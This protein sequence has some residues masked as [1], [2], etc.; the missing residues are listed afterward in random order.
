MAQ[1]A[2][3][4]AFVYGE[5][6]NGD[7]LRGLGAISGRLLDVGSGA[8]AW[9]VRLRDAGAQELVA[10][11]PS[12]AAVAIAR[13][14][15]DTAV[16][17]TLEDATLQDLGGRRFDVIVAADVLEHLVDPWQALLKLRSWA[18]EDA[19]LAVSV[20]NLRFYRL[21][22][23]LVLRGEFEYERS[24]VRDWTH[25][26]W[27]TRLSLGRALNACGWEPQRWVAS[28]SLKG[29][30]LAKVSEQLANDFLRQQLTVVARARQ[31]TVSRSDRASGPAGRRREAAGDRGG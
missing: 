10:L 29:R 8:G 1:P 22:G 6:E 23:N 2:L 27:F 5:V 9:A 21:V 19:L 16:V 7:L 14:R 26:R 30:L 17:G 13:E 11:D 25:L 4:Q 20:P 15:Y 31:Q 18:A 3:E 12:A 24:G 28:A